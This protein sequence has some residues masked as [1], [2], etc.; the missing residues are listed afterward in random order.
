[1]SYRRKKCFPDENQMN[2]PKIAITD[3]FS[4]KLFFYSPISNWVTS[5]KKCFFDFKHKCSFSSKNPNISAFFLKSHGVTTCHHE[6][7]TKVRMIFSP[8]NHKIRLN[9]SCCKQTPSARERPMGLPLPTSIHESSTLPSPWQSKPYAIKSNKT[10]IILRKN[11][12]TRHES[13]WNPLSRDRCSA[14]NRRYQYEDLSERYQFRN[15]LLLSH[16]NEEGKILRVDFTPLNSYKKWQ[17][18]SIWIVRN[19]KTGIRSQELNRNWSQI[20]FRP[21]PL[22][23]GKIDAP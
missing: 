9:S 15:L 20:D 3:E 17:Y 21:A 23:R 6:V 7:V 12:E 2:Q 22:S 8:P 16:E 13:Q 5:E 1:M 10:T 14:A 11:S 4:K 19:I 18:L